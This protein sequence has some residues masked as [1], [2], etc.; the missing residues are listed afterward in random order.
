MNTL[1]LRL[2]PHSESAADFLLAEVWIDGDTPLANYREY[3]VDRDEL[4][5]S[6][7]STGDF[8]ILTCWCGDP[9]CAGIDQAVKVVQEADV[10]HWYIEEPP[11][12]RHLMF[13]R[14][15]YE[16]AIRDAQQT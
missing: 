8:W 10:V 14:G 11:P 16:A 3:A 9:G 12:A 2:V 1:E 7:G 13:S 6:V 5:R 15:Q 4:R